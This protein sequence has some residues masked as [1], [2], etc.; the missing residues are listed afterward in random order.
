[1][2]PIL[3]V[4]ITGICG[5]LTA[6][7]GFVITYLVKKTKQLE[8]KNKVKDQKIEALHNGFRQD[9]FKA[10]AELNKE[11]VGLSKEVKELRTDMELVKSLVVENKTHYKKLENKS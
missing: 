8:E 9:V 10:V 7:F 3:Q 11:A 1:M 6:L 2:E 5:V 4:I